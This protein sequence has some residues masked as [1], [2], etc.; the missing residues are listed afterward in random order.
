[1]EL[2]EWNDNL[3][4]GLN[5]VDKQHHKLVNIINSLGNILSTDNVEKSHLEKVFKDLVEYTTYHF[6]EEEKLMQEYGV[7][8]RHTKAHKIIHLEFLQKVLDLKEEF[9]SNEKE[10]SKN[11]FEFLVN[12]LVYHITGSDM[13]MSRQIESIKSGVS[14]KEAFDI[15][16]SKKERSATMLL[17]SLNNLFEQISKKNKKL[18]ELN[19]NLEKRVKER[20]Q[21]LCDANEK[22]HELATTDALTGIA[23]RRKAME[24]LATLW[25]E[26]KEKGFNLSCIMIDA[27]NFKEINDTYGHDAGDI[28]LVE[29][30]NELQHSV[31][32]DDVVCRLG[33]DEFLIICPLTDEKGV[34]NIANKV[35]EKINQLR[36]RAK[37]G[38]WKGSISVGV[39]SKTD[40]MKNLD[41]LIK[42]ADLGVY[43]SKEAGKNCVRKAE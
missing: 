10:T 26:S 19:L 18:K 20:T 40:G 15:E 37:E 16:S 2:F 25:E 12:W 21:E 29:L 22:L 1:M 28:V 14:P 5:E 4:T 42:Q 17:D 13:S 33:G 7:D 31:R 34:F 23:N 3:E 43:A 8:D 36:V 39:A 35:H 41:E 30:S 9:Y 24:I 27:D 6:D 11:L 38:V 32:T